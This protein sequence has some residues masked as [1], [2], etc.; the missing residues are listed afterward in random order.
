V[1]ANGSCA[2]ARETSC[3]CTAGRLCTCT[4]I[5]RCRGES[6][7]GI[8]LPRKHPNQHPLLTG[9]QFSRPTN[10]TPRATKPK[11][12]Q[13]IVALLRRGFMSGAGRQHPRRPNRLVSRSF[14]RLGVA[15]G[16]WLDHLHASCNVIS[17]RRSRPGKLS[18]HGAGNGNHGLARDRAEM[19]P[20]AFEDSFYRPT[21]L[22][23]PLARAAIWSLKAC[24]LS[25]HDR[26]SGGETA[27][28]VLVVRYTV[29]PS[30]LR[31][32]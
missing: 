17:L 15:L 26:E 16:L 20:W 1:V 2:C 32:R 23:F 10:N 13:G 22:L 6:F 14:N 19:S 30:K 12:S 18:R 25:S 24:S 29:Q 28:R 3:I 9:D 4:K 31:T 5:D 11:K 8:T 7:H 27:F 21:T